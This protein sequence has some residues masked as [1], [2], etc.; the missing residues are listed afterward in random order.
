[1]ELILS[2]ASVLGAILIGAISPA[3]SFV[4]VARTSM[5]ASRIDG[6]FTAIGMGIGGVVFSAVVDVDRGLLIILIACIRIENTVGLME[7]LSLVRKRA[8]L[9]P[10]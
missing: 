1:M 9:H 3:P 6:I 8:L 4:L 7:P 2:L 5:A 10:L